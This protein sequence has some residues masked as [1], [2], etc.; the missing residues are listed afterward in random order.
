MAGSGLWSAPDPTSILNLFGLLPYHIPAFIPAFFSIGIWPIIYGA[1]QWVQTKMNL[2]PRR[3]G[4][5][6]CSR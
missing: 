6:A 2:H 1:T 5:S 3:S 4:A